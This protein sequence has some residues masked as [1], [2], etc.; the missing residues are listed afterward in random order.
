MLAFALATALTT[1]PDSIIWAKASDNLRF[2]SLKPVMTEAEVE[3]LKVGKKS[4]V[5]GCGSGTDKDGNTFSGCSLGYDYQLA[6]YKE[7]LSISFDLIGVSVQ[8]K[9]SDNPPYRWGVDPPPPPPKTVI[10]TLVSFRVQ[11]GATYRRNKDGLYVAEP[12]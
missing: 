10:W 3:R 5:I 11:G 12:K 9:E 7:P 4:D 6:G 2:A 8:K 1:L